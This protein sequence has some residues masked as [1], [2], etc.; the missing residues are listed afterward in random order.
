MCGE[1][2]SYSV[3]VREILC[4]DDFKNVL[5]SLSCLMQKCS[6]ILLLPGREW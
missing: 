2:K 5:I 6:C 1:R 3:V 4:C